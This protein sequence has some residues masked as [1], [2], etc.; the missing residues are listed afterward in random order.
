MAVY[1]AILLFLIKE[2]LEAWRR[3][4][5]NIQKLRI[6]KKVLAYECERNHWFIMAVKD[7]AERVRPQVNGYTVGAEGSGRYRLVLLRSDGT[8]ERSRILPSVHR[9]TFEKLAVEVG[10]IDERMGSLV[11]S[12]LD[13]VLEMEHIRNSIIEFATAREDYHHDGFYKS[14]WEYVRDR[15]VINHEILS[16][17][18]KECTG[19]ELTEFR[20]L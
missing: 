8:L 20:L 11:S 18:Y 16:R 17:L 3:R 12:A 15:L 13:A 1:A 9:A 14:F 2:A 6:F 7:D 4:Q 10:Y 5:G 19:R